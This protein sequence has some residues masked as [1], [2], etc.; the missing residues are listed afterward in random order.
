MGKSSAMNINP[1][2]D[3]VEVKE[4]FPSDT[5]ARFK[6]HLAMPDKKKELVKYGWAHPRTFEPTQILYTV[7]EF[8]FRGESFGNVSTDCALFLGCSNMF[9]VG[10]FEKDTIPRKFTTMTSIPSVNLGQP[11]GSLD[12]AVR[13]AM[14][15]VPIL[16]PAAIFLLHPPGIRRELFL[17]DMFHPNNG[18]QLGN[19]WLQFGLQNVR[20]KDGLD[21]DRET[22]ARYFTQPQEEFCN[23]SRNMYALQ[24]LAN[25]YQAILIEAS[26][27][28]CPGDIARKTLA[29][30]LA[31]PGPAF[32]SW[33]A[34]YFKKIY[35]RRVMERERLNEK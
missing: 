11:G 19:R 4:W 34:D 20:V 2:Q 10:I 5:E 32:A 29:R 33:F 3:A 25:E 26:P 14:Y 21:S 27:K 8:G 35:E 9:G 15:W 12:A 28:D 24:G 23:K 7:N 6:E 13:V 1:N 31:H 16:K 17:D 18:A 30:D 22:F